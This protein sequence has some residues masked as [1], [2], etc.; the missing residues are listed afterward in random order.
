MHRTLLLAAAAVAVVAGSATAG[1]PAPQRTTPQKFAGSQVVVSGKVTAIE[2]DT[3]DA[4]S[5]YGGAPNKIA[6]KIAVVKI[7]TKL[8]GAEN[9]T[10]IKVG[11]IPPAKPNPNA[12]IPPRLG[13]P[14]EPKEGQELLLFLCKHPS[15]EFFLI[16]SLS[17]PV[18]LGAEPGK[19]QL[20]QAKKFAAIVADPVKALKSDKIEARTEAAA[21]MIAKYR[22]YPEFATKSEWVSVPAEESQL[23]LKAL[24]EADW[25]ARNTGP[26]AAMNAFFQLGLTDKDGWKNPVTKPGENYFTS[27][28]D[29]YVKWLDGPG[30]DYQVKK[31]VAKK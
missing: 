29:A 27:H 14:L 13:L 8:A 19:Q 4:D 25:G 17:Q 28:K 9:L 11:Y 24:A 1:A 20:E 16:P 30:K 12:K 2:K 7:D 5:P 23:V 10:H 15:A 26:S 3:V 6:Y 18:E 21:A 22:A 31:I